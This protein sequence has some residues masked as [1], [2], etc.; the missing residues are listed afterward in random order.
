MLSACCFRTA[1]RFLSTV[2]RLMTAYNGLRRL[3]STFMGKKIMPTI[4][5]GWQSRKDWE[6]NRLP[7]LEIKSRAEFVLSSYAI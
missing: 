7:S 6:L 2:W 4:P 3:F 5:S 1:Y